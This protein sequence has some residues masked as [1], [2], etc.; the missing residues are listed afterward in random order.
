MSAEELYQ[1][2]ILDHYRNPRNYGELENPTK[3][4][5]EYNPV[6]GDKLELFLT[7]NEAEFLDD[8]QF[9]GRGC[10]LFL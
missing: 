2:I 9:T 3:F 10:W 8:L 4:V 1:Q 6:C 7:I 5:K